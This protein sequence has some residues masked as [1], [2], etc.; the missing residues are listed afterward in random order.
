[1]KKENFIVNAWVANADSGVETAEILHHDQ[2]P[3]GLDFTRVRFPEP[4]GLALPSA[5]GC[6]VSVIRGGGALLLEGRELAVGEGVHW[7]QPPGFSAR[8]ECSVG[9]ELVIVAAAEGGR[10]RG[11]QFL[12]RDEEFLAACGHE[13]GALR[14][15]LTP[16]YLSRRVFLHHDRTLLSK[17]GNPLSW[18]HTTMFD[19]EGLPKNQEGKSVF[20]MSYNYRT[21]PNLCYEVDGEAMVRMAKHPYSEHNQ[22]WHPWH[23]LDGDTTYHLNE[24][25]CDSEYV[26][27]DGISPDGISPDDL[28]SGKE[29]LPRRNKHEVRIAVGSVSLLCMHDPAPTG[30]ERHSAGEYSEYG[31]LEKVVGSKEHREYL[32]ALKPLDEMVDALSLAKAEGKDWQKHIHFLR[33]Q[34][35]RAAQIGSENQLCEEVAVQTPKRLQ[36]LR[37]WCTAELSTGT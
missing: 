34:A 9:T 27:S 10:A 22:A 16:Q 33:Y 4:G 31:D 12:L 35:G 13:K 32:Q 37:S 11:T 25:V 18:F 7:Y 23:V 14:W 29:R 20:K 26:H 5:F 19:V 17:S 6:I 2:C 15:V 28:E 30:A 24:D 36:I 1:M 21:E 8:V 3:E